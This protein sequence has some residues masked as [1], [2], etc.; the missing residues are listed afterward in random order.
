[1]HE[2]LIDAGNINDGAEN[3]ADKYV[4]ECHIMSSLRH[5]NI[6]QFLGVCIFDDSLLPILATD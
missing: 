1:M 5:P 3:V 4:Q 6:A 2:V